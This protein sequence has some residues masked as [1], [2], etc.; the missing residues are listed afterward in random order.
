MRKIEALMNDAI[1][2]ST[3]MKL[4]NTKVITIVD[5]S[6]VYLHDNLIAMVTDDAVEVYDGGW[7]TTTT[8]SRLNAILKVHA[9]KGECIVQKNFKWY[10]HKFVGQAGSTPVFNEQEFVN[11]FIFA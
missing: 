2:A 1:S 4:G 9:I 5:T 7:Q 3:D 10:I 11:G 8:K 6:F